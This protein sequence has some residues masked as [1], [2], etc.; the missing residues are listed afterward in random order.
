MLDPF[1]SHIS[2]MPYLIW[3]WS[4]SAYCVNEIIDGPVKGDSHEYLKFLI[5]RNK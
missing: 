2:I 5:I 1:G 3:E 4:N